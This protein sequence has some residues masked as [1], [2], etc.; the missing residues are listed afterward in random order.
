MER[1]DLNNLVQATRALYD[2]RNINDQQIKDALIKSN[3]D[4][5]AAI[6]LLTTNNYN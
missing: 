5:D 1:N 2:L 3:R 4:I 6:I